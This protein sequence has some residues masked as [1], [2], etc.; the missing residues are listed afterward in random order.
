M[1]KF[2]LLILLSFMLLSYAWAEEFAKFYVGSDL[3][4]EP[5]KGKNAGFGEFHWGGISNT[6]YGTMVFG[7]SSKAFLSSVQLKSLDAIK[8]L[9]SLV[10]SDNEFYAGCV[11]NTIFY[12]IDREPTESDLEGPAKLKQFLYQS[13]LAGGPNVHPGW[14]VGG[15]L[16]VFANFINKKAEKDPSIYLVGTAYV[17]VYYATN[18]LAFW[19]MVGIGINQGLDYHFV[20]VVRNE[21]KRAFSPRLKLRI[22]ISS[23]RTLSLA[24]TKAQLFLI[25]QREWPFKKDGTIQLEDGTLAP[26]TKLVDS[27]LRLGISFDL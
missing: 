4:F 25:L 2:L 22:D 5:G 23:K 13:S 7:V 21:P 10:Q 19:P 24:G 18:I 27:S 3:R 8:I 9:D 15:R 1:K 16:E 14:G 6:F 11:F 26:A 17:N 20:N 12:H